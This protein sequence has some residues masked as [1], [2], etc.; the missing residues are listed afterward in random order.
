MSL[1]TQIKE[2]IKQAML[3][4]ETVRTETLRGVSSALTNELVSK[5]RKPTD[6]LTD[7]EALA[8]ISRLVKQRKDAIDQFATAGRQDLVDEENAQLAIL[9]TFLPQMMSPEEI[10]PLAEAKKAEL[11]ITDKS[12]AGML[13]GA[14]M[15]DLKGKADGDTVKSVVDSLF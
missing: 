9:I 8:V 10:R 11:G 1:Q 15:K 14:L 3:A 4:R 2:S 6:E 13:V 7:E 12:K 5:G